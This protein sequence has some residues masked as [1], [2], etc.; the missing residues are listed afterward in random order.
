MIIIE[1]PNGTKVHADGVDIA[2]DGHIYAYEQAEDPEVDEEL[3]WSELE[4]DLQQAILDRLAPMFKE[5]AENATPKEIA[6]ASDKLHGTW[7]EQISLND[8]VDSLT[9]KQLELYRWFAQEGP[10][11]VKNLVEVSKLSKG[12]ITTAMIP[13]RQKGLLVRDTA[14]AG[15]WKAVV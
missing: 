5:K 3:T 13:L 8:K 1:L 2:P 11:S 6:L 12:G 15:R 10:I 4:P 14:I 9:P 7:R